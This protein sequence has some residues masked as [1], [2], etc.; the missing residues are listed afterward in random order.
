MGDAFINSGGRVVE[1]LRA[2]EGSY[3]IVARN[4]V[5]NELDLKALPIPEGWELDGVDP[6]SDVPEAEWWFR[7]DESRVP[8]VGRV[9][10][11]NFLMP[12]GRLGNPGAPLVGPDYRRIILR[13]KKQF[14]KVLVVECFDENTIEAVALGGHYL[15]G[16]NGTRNK[17]RIETREVQQ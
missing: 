11:C 13:R 15:I 8:G 6:S 17:F 1:A 12:G 10:H 2:S 9:A 7:S 14:R 16:T 4:N 5:Y 3:L